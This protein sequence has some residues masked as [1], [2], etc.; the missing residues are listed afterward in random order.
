[1]KRQVSIFAIGL[2]A[3]STRVW[4]EPP[5]AD[6]MIIPGTPPIV[7]RLYP[8][9]SEGI[10]KDGSRLPP[11]RICTLGKDCLT[12]DSRPFE[13]C[14]VAG[15][16]CGDKLAEVLQVDKPRIAVKPAPQLATAPR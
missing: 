15:K 14:Q 7:L 10:P 1:M 8:K 3:C 16:S 12:L 4:P 2:L 6:L 11:P 9:P 5:P 13:V